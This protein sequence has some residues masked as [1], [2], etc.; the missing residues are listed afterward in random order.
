MGS[1]VF[2]SAADRRP[3]LPFFRVFLDRIENLNIPFYRLIAFVL[4]LIS[5]REGLEQIFFEK[6][7]ELYLYYHHAFFFLASLAA[8]ILM[9]SLW[10]RTDARRTARVVAAGYFMIIV[11]PLIDRLAFHRTVPYEYARPDEFLRNVLAYFRNA[12]GTGIG[13]LIEITAILFFSFI[14]ILIKTRSPGRAIGGAL[15]LYLLVAFIGTPRLF[16]PL[17]RMNNPEVYNAR[18]ILYFSVYLLAFL[19]LSLVALFL[20]ARSLLRAAVRDML[21]FRSAHF[22]IMVSTGLYFNSRIRLYPFPG[23]LYAFVALL[24]MLFLWTI[25][26]LLNNAHD[27]SI[28]RIANP[29]RPLALGWATPAGYLGLGYTLAVLALFTSGVLGAKDFLITAA[30]LLSAYP[31]SVP[32]FRLRLRLGSNLIIGWGS[33]LAFY[34]GYHAWTTIKEFPLE[35]KPVLVSIIILSALSLG[36]FTKDGKDYE[37][38]LASGVRTVFTVYGPEK[39]GRIASVGLFLSL[40][41][42]LLLLHGLADIVFFPVVAVLTAFL[43]EKKRRLIVP[44]AGYTIIAIYAF[45]RTIG[46]FGGWI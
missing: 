6:P 36:S 20:Y 5:I 34:L 7:F 35:P 17:P 46:L 38:D 28:D 23:G 45:L 22:L 25:T 11:P 4:V 27:L 31:Y 14:Y 19:G 3:L 26:V 37:G 30:F 8:G 15:T 12:P 10:A 43:F 44:F 9:L 13:I 18:H 39:G 16:L 1:E 29:G 2:R 33:F 42:P 40:L 24:I 41:T 21:S 32:P